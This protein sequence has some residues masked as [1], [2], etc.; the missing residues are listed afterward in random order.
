MKKLLFIPILHTP[1]ELDLVAG[2]HIPS[3]LEEVSQEFW[4]TTADFFND[5]RLPHHRMKIY[6]DSLPDIDDEKVQHIV[7]ALMKD[8]PN[9]DLLRSLKKKGAQIIGTEDIDL[10][11]QTRDAILA[12]DRGRSRSLA[13]LRDEKIEERI[14]RTLGEGD[15]GVLF[16]GA[17]HFL[18]TD[19][20]FSSEIEC[21]IPAPIREFYERH[22]DPEV[23]H[24]GGRFRRI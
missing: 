14:E 9:F 16:L 2:E 5:P 22:K 11:F 18:G 21:I 15:L 8:S 19:L 12:G 20:P 17:A 6:Q 13:L 4:R 23:T 10:V 7:D 3:S 1:R 24:E